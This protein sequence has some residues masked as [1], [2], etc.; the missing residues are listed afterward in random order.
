MG[1]FSFLRRLGRKVGGA[2]SG[3]AK[4][5]G[6][7]IQ[8]GAKKVGEIGGKVVDVAKKISPFVQNIPILG[9]VVGAV[10]KAGDLV[11]IA[12]KVGEGDFKGAIKQGLDVGSTMLPGP[13]GEVVRRG[14]QVYEGGRGM[15]LF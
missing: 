3:G 7:V 6:S 5:V 12:K 9:Q 8:Q 4:K 13:A 10:S 2:I 1:L 15:G 11:D 14:R